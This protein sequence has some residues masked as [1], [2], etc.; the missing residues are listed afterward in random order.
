MTAITSRKSSALG[1]SAYGSALGS[2]R[3]DLA[4]ADGS[5]SRRSSIDSIR[6]TIGSLLLPSG[7]PVAAAS[8][9]PNNLHNNYN[10]N[11]SSSI[12]AQGSRD[13]GVV[14]RFP[15]QGN[16]SILSLAIT[17]KIINSNESV[18]GR[19]TMRGSGRADTKSLDFLV[20]CRFE[21]VIRMTPPVFLLVTYIV[22]HTISHV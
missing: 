19:H 9:P 2:A 12:D 5:R 21:Q 1:S 10:N 17:G 7:A 3:G 8:S 20:V 13:G 11:D 6:S 16:Q 14:S 22:T 4:A 18:T 15:T